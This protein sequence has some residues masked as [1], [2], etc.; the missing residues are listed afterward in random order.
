LDGGYVADAKRSHSQY[1]TFGMCP[2]K[3]QLSRKWQPKAKA[4]PLMEGDVFHTVVGK[5]Y[6]TGNI[7]DGLDIFEMAKGSHMEAVVRSGADHE[8]IEKVEMKFS[9]LRVILGLYAEHIVPNDLAFYDVLSVEEPFEI[10]VSETSTI[11]G[12]ID[13][14]FRHKQTGVRHIVEHKYKSKHEE[15]LMPLDLQV[16]MYTLALI[17]KYGLLPTLYNVALKPANRQSK[18]ESTDAF[19][20]RVAESLREKMSGFSW[21]DGDY[22]SDL[23][24]RRVY[25]RGK[26]EL[27]TALAEIRAKDKIMDMVEADPSLVWRNPGDHCLYMCPFKPICMDEDPMLIERMYEPKEE[28]PRGKLT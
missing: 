26:S 3:H 24:V 18:K 7:Q 17:P 11:R 16:S 5:M 13:A 14:V 12:F 9:N 25:S 19:R 15:D 2:R 1:A 23:F 22:Q 27:A 8:Y 4:P 28:S 21:R 6:A 20:A 10:K